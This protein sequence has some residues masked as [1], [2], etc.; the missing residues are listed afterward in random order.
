[1]E[2]A[3][4]IGTVTSTFKTKE[5]EGIK[6]LVIQP[7]DHEEKETSKPIVAIDTVQSVEGNIV[8]WVA[9]RE[10][11]LAVEKSFSPV[12]AAIVGIVD[13]VYVE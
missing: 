3:K 6:L 7:I 8:Y 2:L 12:D 4:V 9:G 5:L 10:A 1:M 13:Q 11:S